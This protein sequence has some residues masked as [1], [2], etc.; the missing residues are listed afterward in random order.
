MALTLPEIH[1]AKKTAIPSDWTEDE[2]GRQRLTLSLE[3]EGAT[4]EGLFLRAT[5]VRS[6]PDREVMFQLEYH[7]A[8]EQLCRIDWRPLRPHRNG[9]V[10]PK[11]HRLREITGSHHHSFKL[12]W[13]PTKEQM[14]PNNL[15]IAEPILPDPSNFQQLLM[16]VSQEFRIDNLSGVPLPAWDLLL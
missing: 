7:P 8:R 13:I 11:A 4:V 14:R 1:A 16:V 10:G 3:I 5:A 2:R 6:L 15:P 12:N 9:D